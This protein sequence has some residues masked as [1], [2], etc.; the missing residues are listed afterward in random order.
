MEPKILTANGVVFLDP[1]FC[2]ITGK[3]I[4]WLHT[5][6]DHDPVYISF[7]VVDENGVVLINTTNI[8]TF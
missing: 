5:D 6:C 4:G 7:D 1:I 2:E 3:Q 8:K